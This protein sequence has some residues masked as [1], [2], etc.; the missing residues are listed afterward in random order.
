MPD[1]LLLRKLLYILSKYRKNINRSIDTTDETYGLGG[2]NP[3]GGSMSRSL[4]FS[5]YNRV[6]N[7]TPTLNCSRDID[8]FT[9]SNSIVGN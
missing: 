8:K 9:V 2:W 7:Y 5:G 4:Y 6:Y 3:D 1:N